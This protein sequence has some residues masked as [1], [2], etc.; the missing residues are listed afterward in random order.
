MKL[1][2]ALLLLALIPEQVF[3]LPINDE[4]MVNNNNINMA[5]HQNEE[6]AE[7]TLNTGII[8]QKDS[9]QYNAWVDESWQEYDEQNAEADE[10]NSET[11]EQNF[12]ATEQ[13]A[14]PT[15]QNY[16]DNVPN[17]FV[18]DENFVEIENHNEHNKVKS[19]EEIA[20]FLEIIFFVILR[21]NIRK[22][23]IHNISNN[24]K[25]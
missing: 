13:N 1:Y 24:D 2:L 10:Q 3:L 14:S 9:K 8:V 16:E 11:T 20:D 12:E 23:S 5:N 25:H 4:Y 6:T 15:E 18:T 21:F 17:Y 7:Q 22:M 19:A